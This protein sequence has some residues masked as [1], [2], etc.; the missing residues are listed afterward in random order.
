MSNA[1]EE[2][3][4]QARRSRPIRTA[5]Y[6]VH[7][8]VVLPSA[9]GG[10]GGPTA[11]PVRSPA[12]AIVR[13]VPAPPVRP[14]SASQTD[15]AAIDEGWGAEP[16]S[17]TVTRVGPSVAVV[18]HAS[19]TA[20][21]APRPEPQKHERLRGVAT[22]AVRAAPVIPRAETPAATAP[23]PV[24]AIASASIPRLPPKLP[25][26]R[27][28]RVVPALSAISREVTSLAGVP[29]LKEL[30][31]ARAD[32]RERDEAERRL[33]VSARASAAA[34]GRAGGDPSV[35]TAPR[36]RTVRAAQSLDDSR[37]LFAYGALVGAIAVG[38]SVLVALLLSN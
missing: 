20:L 29:T 36:D 16:A 17:G 13:V 27:V 3:M 32:A 1:L 25:E 31:T 30:L 6:G 11:S 26:V 2:A 12:A 23:R 28:R 9:R 24:P 5:P 4:S 19:A 15:L 7:G 14:A 33:S 35:V 8:P 37:T 22:P 10:D 38:L 34:L 21:A 18:A